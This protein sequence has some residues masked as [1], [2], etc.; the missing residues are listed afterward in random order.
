MTSGEQIKRRRLELGYSVDDVAEKLGKNR[1][2]I[3][4]YENNEIE[5][6]P[7]TVL[8]PLAKVLNTTPAHLMGWEETAKKEE[9]K[10][11]IK[12]ESEL[13]YL[14]KKCEKELTEEQ[15]KSVID[16]MNFMFIKNKS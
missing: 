4:R 13:I 14:A 12:E 8:M 5:N 10:E 11:D 1:A 7:A 16:Y 2:T 6:L 9:T 15:K 3:Y